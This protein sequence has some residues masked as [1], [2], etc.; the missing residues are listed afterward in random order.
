MQKKTGMD[1]QIPQTNDGPEEI[2]DETKEL[3]TRASRKA[4]PR[5]EVSEDAAS[6]NAELADYLDG[7]LEPDATPYGL[8]TRKSHPAPRTS[9]TSIKSVQ[10]E[11]DLDVEE[12]ANFDSTDGLFIDNEDTI[13]EDAANRM[14]DALGLDQPVEEEEDARSASRQYRE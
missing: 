4:R 10:L 2:E 9:R 8:G 12:E 11:D 14:S 1:A 5:T 3:Q 13:L 6:L 7:T